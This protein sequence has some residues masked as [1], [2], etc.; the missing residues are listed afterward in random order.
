MP[1]CLGTREDQA[2]QD[3]RIA[4]EKPYSKEA[5]SLGALMDL[6]TGSDC[7]FFIP[8]GVNQFPFPW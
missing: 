7:S 8:V 6:S 3:L 1:L 5:R 4:W 2:L